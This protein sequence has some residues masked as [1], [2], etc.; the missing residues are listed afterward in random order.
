MYEWTLWSISFE[1]KRKKGN[2][3]RAEGPAIYF[4]A[5][6]KIKVNIKLNA[7]KKVY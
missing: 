2:G 1:L 6:D 5:T 3:E 7:T 4:S